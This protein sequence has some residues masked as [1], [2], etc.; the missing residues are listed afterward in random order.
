M[1]LRS[2]WQV[3]KTA[4][5]NW[6]NHKTSRQSAAVAF[7]TL[8]SLVPLLIIAITIAGFIWGP[9]VA[10]G[11]ALG[12]LSEF[13][14]PDV[15]DMIHSALRNV[16]HAGHG[17]G[18]LAILISAPTL[19]F[20]ATGVLTELQN[21]MDAVWSAPRRKGRAI[22]V[23]TRRRLWSLV[24]IGLTGAVLILSLAL[25]AMLSSAQE[26]LGQLA[27]SLTKALWQYVN[28]AVTLALVI[29]VFT[30]LYKFLPDIR[31]AWRDVFWGAVLA[32]V[33][34]TVG[35]FFIGLYLARSAATSAF[36]AAGAVL[37]LLLWL[38]YS[39]MIFF[40]GAEF[41]QA[42]AQLRATSLVSGRR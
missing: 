15:A 30:A 17:H 42:R 34:F 6:S 29:A 38:Y 1:R 19:L 13:V 16:H 25:S 10:R 31:T 40:F 27:P 23:Y 26:S 14:G 9:R 22:W 3:L 37:A 8:F 36:G 32:G 12:R 35:K 33:L 39:G 24:L 7:Y 2:L 21:A 18:I 41:A 4:V 28:Q 20:G 11:E 5:V